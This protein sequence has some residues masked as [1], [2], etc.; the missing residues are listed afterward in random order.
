MLRVFVFLSVHD[1][2]VM[3]ERESRVLIS[4]DYADFLSYGLDE[5]D[6]HRVGYSQVPESGNRNVRIVES[7]LD[8]SFGER[9]R[10]FLSVYR[11]LGVRFPRAFVFLREFLF[12]HF[13]FRIRN[14]LFGKESGLLVPEERNVESFVPYGALVELVEGVLPLRG[15]YPSHPS[16]VGVYHGEDDFPVYPRRLLRVLVEYHAAEVETAEAV[17]V[18]RTEERQRRAVRIRD[19]EFGGI[20]RESAYLVSELLN[21]APRYLLRLPVGRGYVPVVS[22]RLHHGRHYVKNR[23]DG[24]PGAAVHY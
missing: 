4:V 7:L 14:L 15:S 24:F 13:G 22:A 12:G 21:H 20:I 23:P 5:K 8:P 6:G 18:F 16:P 1:V 17:R 19:L 2:R 3:L 10:E 9:P 11:S